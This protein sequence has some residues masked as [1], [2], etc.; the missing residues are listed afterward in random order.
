MYQNADC[1]LRKKIIVSFSITFGT[2]SFP[3]FHARIRRK[4]GEVSSGCRDVRGQTDRQT[5]HPI[6]MLRSASYRE[7]GEITSKTGVDRGQTDRA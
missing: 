4:Y 7:G 1:S 5:P 2:L 3:A 6:A